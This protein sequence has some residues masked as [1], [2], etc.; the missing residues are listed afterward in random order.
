MATEVIY[1][2]Q[3]EKRAA[4]AIVERAAARNLPTSSAIRKIAE[5]EESEP[6]LPRSGRGSG[7]PAATSAPGRFRPA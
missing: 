7:S 1:V 6:A 5:A 4:R 3:A 2:T